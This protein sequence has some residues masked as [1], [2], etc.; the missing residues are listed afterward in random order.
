MDGLVELSEDYRRIEQ[1]IAYLEA[2]A[3][4]QPSLK[5]IAEHVHLSEYHFQ[6]LFTRW[7]GISPK[8]FL[9]YLTKE[10][11]RRLLEQSESVLEA[12]LEA[13]LSSPGRLHDLFLTCEAVTPGQVKVRGEG[14][15]IVYGFHA[16]PFGECLLALT[17]RGVCGLSFVMEGRQASLEM[18]S[19]RWSRAALRH[20]Q[21]ES[22]AW[23]GR[24]FG[25]RGEGLPVHL[26][27]TNFQIQVWEAL[28]RIP[29]GQLVSYRQLAQKVGRTGA[30][31]AVG[32]AVAANPVMYLIPCH[33]VI[34]EVGDFGSYQ[35]GS[36]RKKAMGVW[37]MR[38]RE[39]L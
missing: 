12:A 16:S 26:S 10:N 32:Q 35:G 4:Q 7:A 31:R 6:R 38:A 2:H 25:E 29:P 14:T 5:E 24:I 28:L 27:G 19:Q 13:G 8:R 3:R 36:A 34:R 39:T 18:L 1:A 11:A 20:S 33:R 21:E 22:G 30:S 17:E 9:Q 15:E 37:E 23:M